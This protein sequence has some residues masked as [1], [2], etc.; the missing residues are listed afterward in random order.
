MTGKFIVNHGSA[1]MENVYTVSENFLVFGKVFGFFPF[2]FTGPSR[3][4]IFSTKWHDVVALCVMLLIISVLMTMNLLNKA[5]V[6]STSLMVTNAWNISINI[7][8]ISY[9]LIIGYQVKKRKKIIEYLQQIAV[10]DF[11]VCF[12]S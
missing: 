3:K 12:H 7:E 8:I 9:L 2:S 5:Y 11:K 1:K 6:E 4:G 10:V